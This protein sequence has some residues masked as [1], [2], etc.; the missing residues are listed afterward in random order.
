MR[1]SRAAASTPGPGCAVTGLTDNLTKN[2]LQLKLLQT[3][4]DWRQSHMRPHRHRNQPTLHAALDIPSCGHL[5]AVGREGR[6]S[7]TPASILAAHHVL[8]DSQTGREPPGVPQ[9]QYYIDP[10]FG[11]RLLALEH[12]FDVPNHKI[13]SCNTESMKA[14][15]GRRQRGGTSRWWLTSSRN[16]IGHEPE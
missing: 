3:P 5:W 15:S 16:R 11:T 12:L 6:R 7:V 13:L 4:C 8:L 2:Y 9:I 14:F 1:S 10:S